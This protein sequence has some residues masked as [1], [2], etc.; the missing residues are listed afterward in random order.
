MTL[1]RPATGQGWVKGV[2]RCPNAVLPPWLKEA[3]SAR[4]ATWPDPEPVTDPVANRAQWTR[5]QV[6]V[7]VRI[8]LPVELPP[9][10]L[11]L[12]WDNM[13][14]HQTPALVLWLFA[15]GVMVL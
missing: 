8:T 9:L 5:W 15:Q 12:V 3:V 7:K 4:L 11:L 2:T 10:R 6:G 1:L 13:T 14:G